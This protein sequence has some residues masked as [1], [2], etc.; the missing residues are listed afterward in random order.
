M[1][2]N[3]KE[4]KQNLDQKIRAIFLKNPTLKFNYKQIA[5]KIPELEAKDK[6]YI[7]GMLYSLAK[8][9]FLVEVYTGKFLLNPVEKEKLKAIGPFVTGIVDMKQT[10]KAYIITPDLLE[11]IYIAPNNTHQ[12]LN[13][14]QVKVR[15]FPK[16]KN[17]KTEGEIIEILKREKTHFVGTIQRHQN[18]AFLIPDNKSTP[19]DIFIPLEYLNG[20][21][22]G[23]KAV[24]ELTEWPPQAKNPFGKIVKVLGQPGEN[25][26]EIHAILVEYG[27]PYAFE[28]NVEKEAEKIEESISSEEIAK[29]RDFRPV[30]T[31]TIDP[32]DAKDFD[33]AISFQKLS[34]DTYQI[35]VHIADVTHYVKEKSVLEEEAYNRATSVYLVDRVVPMLPERLS[36]FICSLRPNEDKLTFSVVFDMNSSGKIL[37]TWIGKTIINSNRRFTY[38][39]VQE[40]IETEKGEYVEEILIT[41]T[42][43]QKIRNKRMKS[44]AIGFDKKEVKFKLDDHGKPLEV[45]FKE[46][47]D[48]HK[49]IEEFMLLAN[50]AVAEKIGKVKSGAKPKTFV[51]R[52]HDIPNPDKLNSLAEFVSKLGYKMRTDT[53]KNISSSFNTLLTQSA[54]KG[55][56][57]LIETLAIRSMA[58]A[59][60]ST[61]NIGHYGLAFD[62]YTHFTSPIRRYP[63]MLVHRM[64]FA[65]QNGSASFNE[66][67]YEEKCIHSTEMEKRAQNAERDSIKYKQV[68][69]LSDKIGQE[70]SGVISG[71]SKWGIFVE[72]IE[73]KCEGMIRLR[74]LSDDYY[75]LDEDNYQVIGHNTKRK[76]KLGDEINIRIKRADFQRKEIDFELAE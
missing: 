61:Q 57:N 50:K 48:A 46:Q 21:K 62:H 23:Q 3:K 63:D 27:L 1:K 66:E 38:E 19:V 45:Y 24:A 59:E 51:Y 42:I 56:E 44:G 2:I 49:L 4:I 10:G 54:G 30:L 73:N 70:F 20:A 16:R 39:E 34:D 35:G 55:E 64:L 41:N 15:L 76:L 31:F 65:Y 14:D 53:R 58:K 22:E 68:E 67:L 71:V 8:E 9:K 7:S 72:I 28:E 74:D 52:I 36:N 17:A 29:R 43:A 32:F 60:Y 11:D 25:E 18:F 13:G 75:Y 47:K 40:I 6:K 33:D 37:S 5:K 69:F 26:V 12:A